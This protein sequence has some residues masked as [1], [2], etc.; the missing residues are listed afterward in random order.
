MLIYLLPKFMFSLYLFW[1]FAFC[2]AQD[3]FCGVVSYS[4]FHGHKLRLLSFLV[5]YIK[6]SSFWLVC[7]FY[8]VLKNCRSELGNLGYI[9]NGIGLLIISKKKSLLSHMSLS[10]FMGN[11]IDFILLIFLLAKRWINFISLINS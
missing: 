6:I 11:Q 10:S 2:A 7:I 3:I 5:L 8:L 1:H 4:I 9:Y